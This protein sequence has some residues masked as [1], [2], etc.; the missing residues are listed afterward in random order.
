MI[1]GR[2]VLLGMGDEGQKSYLRGL[3][4]LDFVPWVAA[5]TAGADLTKY[6]DPGIGSCLAFIYPSLL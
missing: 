2:G 6:L 3:G 5:F 1:Q 4:M